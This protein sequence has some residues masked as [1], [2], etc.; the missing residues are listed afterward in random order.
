MLGRELRE[1]RARQ[2]ANDL[3]WGHRSR[4]VFTTLRGQPQGRR[5]ALRAVYRAG[6]QAGLNPEGAQRVGLHDLRHSL[7]GLA[8]AAGMT[9]PEAANLARHANPGVT[10]AMY[11]GLTETDRAGIT[12]KLLDSGFGR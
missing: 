7:I 1:H 4:F 8:L 5:N 6:D 9:P 2:R 12:Q 10:M 11:A 3:R